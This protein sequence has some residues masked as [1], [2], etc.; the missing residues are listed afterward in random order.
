MGDVV[1]L[2]GATAAN[3]CSPSKCIPAWPHPR[4]VTIS[5]EQARA[6][7]RD[8]RHLDAVMNRARDVKAISTI[9]ST[10]CGVEASG[11][12]RAARAIGLW[13]RTGRCL[14]SA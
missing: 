9:L 8:I 10:T 11:A 6:I 14:K 3:F 4:K 5:I 2:P 7:D 12:E 1:A 13:L